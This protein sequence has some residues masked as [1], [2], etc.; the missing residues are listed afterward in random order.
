MFFFYTVAYEPFLILMIVL[1][2]SLL[3]RPGR[4]PGPRWGS[5]L[6]LAYAA[7][8]VG[9]SLF[10]LPVWIGDVIPY[11]QWRWRMWFNSWI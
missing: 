7:A 6:V 10:F 1:A 2:L 8:V 9:V 11:D 3:L 4:R 5:A